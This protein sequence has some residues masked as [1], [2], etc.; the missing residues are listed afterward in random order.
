MLKGGLL[1]F[2]FNK[3]DMSIPLAPVILLVVLVLI[4]FRQRL[5]LLAPWKA[6]GAGALAVLLMGAISPAQALSSID[7]GVMLFLYGMLVL[8]QGLEESGYLRHLERRA[9]GWTKQPFHLLL[10]LIFGVGLAS[11]LLFNDVLVIIGTPMCILMA[12][13]SKIEAGPLLIALALAVTVGS[14]MSPIGNPQNFLIASRPELPNPFGAFLLYLGVPTLLSLFG[15][16]L[17]MWW[18]YPS[19]RK[20][21]PLQED[22]DGKEDGKSLAARAAL[23]VVVTLSAIR[24][25]GLFLPFIPSF[26]L[27]FIALAGAAVYV[28]G[29]HKVE[30]ALKTDWE[31]LAFFMAMFVLMQAVWM[32][33]FFQSFMPGAQ[34]LGEAPV[35]ILSSLLLSQ[36]LSNVPFVIFYL[37]ALGAGASVQALM[38]LAM[39]STMAGALTVIGA[40]S[41]MIIIQSAAKRHEELPVGGFM[42]MGFVIT[43]VTVCLTLG[44]MALLGALGIG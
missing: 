39:A 25:A 15:L 12:S 11:A 33:G 2:G 29:S 34:H 30:N 44:W 41:N 1:G 16:V 43:T 13:R 19:L 26:E 6:M 31:T 23:A 18:R 20:L 35:V 38:L 22:A 27:F 36:V 10:A 24:L 7:W 37:K 9:L 14:V 4:L 8:G 17:L 5:G 28:V 32:S 3:K 42:T 21:N 40:A